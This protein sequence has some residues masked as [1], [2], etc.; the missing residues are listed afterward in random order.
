MVRK[1]SPISPDAVFGRPDRA[2]LYLAPEVKVVHLDH[3][4]HHAGLAALGLGHT[5]REVGGLPYPE[6]DLVRPLADPAASLNRHEELTEAG[7]MRC[8]LAARVEPE[9]ADVSL[10]APE[11][12]RC[13]MSCSDD[14][15]LLDPEP[16]LSREVNDLHNPFEP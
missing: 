7:L 2:S 16:I 6:F 1:R 5:S 11:R 3:Q 12:D 14:V 13:G 15:V 10:T 4:R 9:N 8:H